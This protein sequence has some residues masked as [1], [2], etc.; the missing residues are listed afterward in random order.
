MSK[1]MTISQGGIK[2]QSMQHVVFGQGSNKTKQITLWV[3]SQKHNL[4]TIISNYGGESDNNKK[5]VLWQKYN[6]QQKGKGT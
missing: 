5:C 6:N 3:E 2:L 1:N 4:S